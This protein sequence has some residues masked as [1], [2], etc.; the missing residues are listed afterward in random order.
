MNTRLMP[1]P[2]AALKHG[3]ASSDLLGW[4]TR[5]IMKGPHVRA[6]ARLDLGFVSI[7]GF[8]CAKQRKRTETGGVRLSARREL[9]YAKEDCGPDVD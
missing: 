5:P 7:N 3:T 9:K 8:S 4:S 2:A 6:A 1:A